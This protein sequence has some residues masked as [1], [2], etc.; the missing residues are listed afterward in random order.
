MWS[1]DFN[2][3]AGSPPSPSNWSFD[4]GAWGSGDGELQTYTGNAA[5]VSLDGNGDL[6]ITA[7]KQSS[8]GPDGLT[9]HYTSARLETAG[10]F[11][12]T[13]GEVEARMK[14]PA[15][16]GLWPA[17]W[18]LGD[19]INSVGWPASGEIDVMEM[20]G[21]DTSRV[22]GTVHGPASGSTP[23]YQ[24]QGQEVSPGSLADAFHTFGVIWQAGRITW[25]LDGVAYAT[26]TPSD[27]APGQRWVFDGHP[28]HL[29]LNLAVGGSWPGPPNAST[30]LPSTL[31]VDWVRVYQ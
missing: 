27:L 7:L 21:Q 17:F 16:Q 13:Y 9:R 11:S 2:G 3:P 25:T 5:N 18:L 26:V 30:P 15:G 12:F 24:V 23:N 29:I 19:D 31:S 28:F 6:A 22:Y 4:L 1:D 14:I 20:L 10:L 8:T